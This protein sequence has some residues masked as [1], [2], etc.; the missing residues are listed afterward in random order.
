MD[1][2]GEGRI[3]DHRLR[4]RLAYDQSP[5]RCGLGG[6]QRAHKLADRN[7]LQGRRPAFTKKGGNGKKSGE[8]HFWPGVRPTRAHRSMMMFMLSTF[9]RAGLSS[10][11]L[12]P[13]RASGVMVHCALD[14]C[15]AAPQRTRTRIHGLGYFWSRYVG[16]TR[17]T[18]PI[19]GHDVVVVSDLAA[20][21]DLG[22]I[23]GQVL[24]LLFGQRQNVRWHGRLR[25]QRLLVVDVC[26]SMHPPTPTAVCSAVRL[27]P[28]NKIFKSRRPP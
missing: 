4:R 12:R 28:N 9:V 13:A 10:D 26:R 19:Q 22:H 16:V 5:E 25:V 23:A 27:P 1:K 15:T 11:A 21:E 6:R 17:G 24:Q 18:N 14:A 2:D 3:D 8:P 7:A 20:G